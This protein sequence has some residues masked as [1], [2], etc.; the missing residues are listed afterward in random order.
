MSDGYNFKY[1]VIT[2]PTY[3]WCS[4]KESALRGLTNAKTDL[5]IAIDKINGEIKRIEE[6]E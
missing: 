5:A 2:H 3:D 1:Y 4:K 6:M